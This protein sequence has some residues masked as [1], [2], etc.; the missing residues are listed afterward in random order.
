M[1][2]RSVASFFFAN[3]KKK[4]KMSFNPLLHFNFTVDKCLSL[5]LLFL[6]KMVE[7][8]Y[9]EKREGIMI[10]NYGGAHE[11]TKIVEFNWLEDSTELLII[12]V[13]RTFSSLLFSAK[14][15]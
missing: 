9:Y 7:N 8:Y 11:I 13:M 14:L 3:I 12:V 1:K 2:V 5:P 4:L 15:I 10:I 6:L